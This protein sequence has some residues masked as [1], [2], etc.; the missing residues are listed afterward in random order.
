MLTALLLVA[1]PIARIPR[2]AVRLPPRCLW[3]SLGT[4]A[5]VK[6][7]AG[8]APMLRIGHVEWDAVDL[9]VIAV[10]MTALAVQLMVHG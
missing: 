7:A 1:V 6:L 2:G 9:S 3:V 5:A 4:A 8:G 10:C